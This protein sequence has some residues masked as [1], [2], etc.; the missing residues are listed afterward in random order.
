MRMTDIGTVPQHAKRAK[1]E[2]IPVSEYS[3]RR[4][5]KQG[6][7]PARY[8]GPKPVFSYTA[9]MRYLSC[10]DGSDNAPATRAATPCIRKVDRE[11]SW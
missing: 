8:I 1:A 5:I 7:I 10:E 11:V 4:L 3:I 9:L 2:G 6:I